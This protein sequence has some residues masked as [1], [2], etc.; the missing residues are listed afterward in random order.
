MPGP[1]RLGVLTDDE[2]AFGHLLRDHL[3]GLA[4]MPILERDAKNHSGPSAEPVCPAT[5]SA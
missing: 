4:G 3:E 1:G 5:A 2:D